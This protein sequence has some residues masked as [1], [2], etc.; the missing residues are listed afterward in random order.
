MS[1]IEI[2]LGLLDYGSWES[3]K[4]VDCFCRYAGVL[5]ERYKG[6]VRYWLTFNEINAMSLQPCMAGE[7]RVAS[8]YP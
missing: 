7:S 8:A 5:L 1:H 6:K 4:I 3:R 2:P